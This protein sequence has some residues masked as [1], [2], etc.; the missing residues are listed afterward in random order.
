MKQFKVYVK[1]W[2]FPSDTVAFYSVPSGTG[3]TPVGDS[4]WIKNQPALFNIPDEQTTGYLAI[5]K[6]PVWNNVQWSPVIDFSQKGAWDW[7]LADN[8]VK[9]HMN[10]TPLIVL[11]VLAIV[12]VS[13][14]RRK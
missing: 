9:P 3:Y 10:I 2:N 14:R 8:T 13:G 1:N 11:A 6:Y 12:V 5:A 4:G 7:D